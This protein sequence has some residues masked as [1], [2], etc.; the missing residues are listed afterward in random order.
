MSGL[1]SSLEIGRKSLLA[2]QQA[3]NVTSNNIANVNTPGYSRQQAVLEASPP[4]Q[5]GLIQ[6]GTG[7]DVKSIESARDRY[8]EIRVADGTQ[9]NGK[10]QALVDSLSQIEGIFNPGDNSLQAAI[11]QLFNSFS[12]LAND[13]SSS[14]LRNSVAS[15][16]QN[17]SSVFQG[18]AQQLQD[19]QQNANSSV[20]D[21]VNKINS[22]AASIAS[23]NRN[24]GAAEAVGG[25]A[26]TLRDQRTELVNQLSELIDVHY[27][28]DESGNFSVSVAGGQ[29]LV[30]A[31]FVRPLTT[32]TAPPSGFVQI[33]SGSN[34]ITSLIQGGKIAGW[35]QVRDQKIPGY[36]NELDT[37]AEGIISQ[38]NATHS[39]GTDLQVP[40]SN[41]S[42]NFFNPVAGV[43]GA[44][45]AFSLNP[46]IAADLKNIAAGQ[47]GSP[48]DNA[49]ALALANLANQKVLSGG[50]ETF[51]QT[52]ASLQFH[53]GTD[54]Q[55]AKQSLD[56]Q[57]ALLSQL[58]NQRDSISG[59]SLD[60]EA[61]NLIR[62]Q[63]AYQASAKFISTIDQ[64][65]S[66]LMQTLVP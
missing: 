58:Q 5:D 8:L 12:T 28:E 3:L 36:Q 14:S 34:D 16:A 53:I 56:T 6:I 30:T 22:L 1:F 46:A 66:D 25:D 52:L 31:D 35:L 9:S 10:Q 48:G 17:L 65:T 29:S 24:I 54:A 55:S 38:V 37:L 42:L 21:A 26:A 51:A 44:A 40:P 64:L 33:K 19:I 60:E 18:S 11:S 57:S 59:V 63:R 61:V 45:K 23:L 15:A 47:S 20:I 4:V 27:Y 50:T 49:N 62:F 32:A 41:P 2:Q 13:P 43:A 7:V 39:A